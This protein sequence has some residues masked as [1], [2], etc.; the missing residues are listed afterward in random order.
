MDKSDIK[1]DKISEIDENSLTNPSI[2][3]TS[4]SNLSNRP[5]I[6]CSNPSELRQ[7]PP[8]SFSELFKK[9]SQD[10]IVRFTNLKNAV[11]DQKESCKK[12]KKYVKKVLRSRGGL[13]V[14]AN[15][16]QITKYFPVLLEEPC[17][18]SYGKRKQNDSPTE[19][20]KKQRVG[21]TD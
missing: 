18:R 6:L 8:R 20:S 3:Q 17:I 7:I 21:S 16:N 11:T 13:S 12:R 2:Y 1:I 10:S 9:S 5:W 15:D 4:S 19:K 14:T